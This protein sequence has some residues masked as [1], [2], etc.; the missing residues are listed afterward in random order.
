M[1]YRGESEYKDFTPEKQIKNGEEYLN[2]LDWALK[3]PDIKNIA[4]SGPY[5]SGKSSIIQSY[6]EKHP[7]VKA[8]NI[9]LQLLVEK[10]AQMMKI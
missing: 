3:N 5:G 2:A 8:L 1:V 6:M 7:S 9:S 4:L 10:A